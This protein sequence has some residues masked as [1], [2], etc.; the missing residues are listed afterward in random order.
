MQW[1]TTPALEPA[2]DIYAGLYEVSCTSS[3]ACTAV[4]QSGNSAGTVDMPLAERWNGTSW[5]VQHPP[6]PAWTA[7]PVLYSLDGSVAVWD[8]PET[9]PATF[10]IFA[11]GSAALTG[12]HWIRWND[13]TATTSSATYY[14]RSGPCCT[15]SDQHYYKVTVTLSGVKYSGGP[16]IGP[17][18]SRM[19]VSGPGLRPL[20][21]TYKTFVIRGTV[22]GGWT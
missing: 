3:T 18:F 8:Y 11:D 6:A 22:S 12:M 10:T 13:V 2:G 21:Y 19:T 20:T 4:G 16:R 9:R 15:N 7:P 14:D 17:Y 5:T 1:A